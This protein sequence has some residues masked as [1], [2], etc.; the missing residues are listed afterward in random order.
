ML[1]A[2]RVLYHRAA[3]NLAAR[4]G[5]YNTAIE[6]AEASQPMAAHSKSAA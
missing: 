4:R 1:T 3:C 6:N 5:E 2:Q